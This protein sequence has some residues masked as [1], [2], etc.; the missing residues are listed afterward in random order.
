MIKLLQRI[1]SRIQMERKNT[2]HQEWKRISLKIINGCNSYTVTRRPINNAFDSILWREAMGSNPTNV[3]GLLGYSGRSTQLY[4]VIHI[5]FE[6]TRR[7]RYSKPIT[8]ETRQQT[9]T[10]SPPESL[11]IFTG[12]GAL[13][14][15]TTIGKSNS[16]S[17]NNLLPK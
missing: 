5:S 10:H 16:T 9:E 8:N 13:S 7:S 6:L 1:L 12:L 2:A 11:F 14:F 15:S 4:Q 17:K 3:D